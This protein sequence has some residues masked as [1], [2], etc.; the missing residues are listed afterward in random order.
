MF[1]YRALEKKIN[2]LKKLL[3]FS[4]KWNKNDC[5]LFSRGLSSNA[6]GKWARNDEKENGS[7]ELKHK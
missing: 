1:E 7:V 3:R 6:V 5:A 4:K 2:L